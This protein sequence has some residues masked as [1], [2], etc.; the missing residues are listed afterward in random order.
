[1]KLI[2]DIIEGCVLLAECWL[3]VFHR[4]AASIVIIIESCLFHLH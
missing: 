4:S 3:D 2:L 1:M